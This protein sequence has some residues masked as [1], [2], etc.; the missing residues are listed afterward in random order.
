MADKKYLC[1]SCKKDITNDIG[2]TRF[3]CPSCG[4]VEVVRCYDC[5]KL[6][7]RYKCHECGF[8]GPN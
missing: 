8:E 4:N 2:S 3:N 6:G 7:T 5:R 1:S